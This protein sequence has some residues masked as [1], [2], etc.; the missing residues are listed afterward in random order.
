MALDAPKL[1]LTVR[2]TDGL[3]SL[4]RDEVDVIRASERIS[5][6]AM[7]STAGDSFGAGFIAIDPEQ[8]DPSTLSVLQALVEG[9]TF[10]SA[11]DRGIILGARLARNLGVGMGKR[12]VY[13]MTDLDGEIV[14][15]VPTSIFRG[16]EET[17]WWTLLPSEAITEGPNELDLFLVEG[18]I[19]DPVLRPVPLQP[20]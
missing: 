20:T 2:R 15:V 9:Q 13:T 11:S 8:D 7:L 17:G 10:E 18:D 12:V 6:Q 3:R 4:A 1:A 16:F 5:G 19:A 14:A